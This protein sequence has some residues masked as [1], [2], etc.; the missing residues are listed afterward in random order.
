MIESLLSLWIVLVESAVTLTCTENQ[1]NKLATILD[2]D[3]IDIRLKNLLRDGSE[4]ITQT[5][6]PKGVSLPEVIKKCAACA[7]WHNCLSTPPQNRSELLF[8]SMHSLPPTPL[9]IRRGRGFACGFKGMTFSFGSPEQCEALIELDGGA[10]I[11]RVVLYNAG[12][13]IG[14]GAHTVLRQMVA[15]AVN[16]AFEQVELVLS[17]TAKS[18]NSGSTAASR[19]TWMAGHAIKLAAEKAL[20]AWRNEDRP[21]RG[22]FRY[23][24]PPTESLQPETGVGYP[25]RTYGYVAQYV[26][27]SV[28][29]E[30]GHINV[31]RVVCANDVGKAINPNLIEGQI[32]GGIVQAYGY[33][34]TENLQVKNGHILNPRLSTYL[35]PGIWDIPERVESVI[36]EIPD[37]LGPWGVR[38]MAE[39]PFIPLAPAITGALYDA[40]GVWFDEIPLTPSRVVAKLRE[41]GIGEG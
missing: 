3:P 15:E 4:F 11:E 27:V 23:V 8:R 7:E 40:T 9:A 33:A 16:V 24:P 21:A 6:M 34:V 14:Q 41:H 38:G 37:P 20:E 30:T 25:F 12:A 18:V 29:I 35:I 36:M 32:E 31:D 39:M 10:E 28:D 2:M 1:I 13:D 17:D 26:E 22:H 19:L 5:I